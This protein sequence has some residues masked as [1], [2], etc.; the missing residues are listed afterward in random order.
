[1]RDPHI[2]SLRSGFAYLLII[3]QS[4]YK[5][6]RRTCIRYDIVMIRKCLIADMVVYTHSLLCIFKQRSRE[7]KSLCISAVQTDKQIIGLTFRNLLLCVCRPLDHG[8]SIRNRF[9][10]YVHGKAGMIFS[11]IIIQSHTGTDTVPVRADM[12]AKR[13]ALLSIQNIF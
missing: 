6:R 5:F 3:Q 11:Q 12:T 7:S 2:E 1:M 8:I 9:Q 4:I 13:N 10:I